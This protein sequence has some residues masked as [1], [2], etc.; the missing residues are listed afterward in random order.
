MIISDPRSQTK[1]NK[2][3]ALVSIL[4]FMPTILDLTNTAYP[5][6]PFRDWQGLKPEDEIYKGVSCLPGKS[7][8]GILSGEQDEVN[9]S[10]LIEN[11]DDVRGVFLRT[12]ITSE[13]KITV[14]GGRDYGELFHLKNDPEERDNL[15]DNPESQALKGELT[16]RLLDKII[17]SEP[18]LKHRYGVA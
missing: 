5:D 2:S 10:I 7:L 9:D 4:D 8:T 15:W 16:A 14:Y 18:R 17:M 1:G 12:L 13:Y 3:D 6:P 11:D